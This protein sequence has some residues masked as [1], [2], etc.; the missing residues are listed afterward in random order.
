MR[1]HL[2]SNS[3]AHQQLSKPDFD[4]IKIIIGQT[5]MAPELGYGTNS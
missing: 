5:Y 3:R 4:L 1:S 2:A